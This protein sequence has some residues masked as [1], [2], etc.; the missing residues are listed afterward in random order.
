MSS[1][2]KPSKQKS[3]PNYLE[4]EFLLYTGATICIINAIKRTKVISENDLDTTES[5]KLRTASNELLPTK[6]LL[7]LNLF[8]MKNH[9]FTL[10]LTFAIADTKLSICP[11]IN[12]KHRY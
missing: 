4:V 3:E 2:A 6:G 10:R 1:E 8:P 9:P 12:Q 5:T 7:H 11:K